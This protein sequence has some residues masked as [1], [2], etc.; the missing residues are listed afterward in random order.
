MTTATATKQGQTKQG[1]TKQGR[2]GPEYIGDGIFTANMLKSWANIEKK[3]LSL[4]ISQEAIDFVK[5]TVIYPKGHEEHM[6]DAVAGRK[7][8][9][10]TSPMTARGRAY[11]LME[12]FIQNL[13]TGQK[14]NEYKAKWDESHQK[15]KPQSTRP[16]L[17]IEQKA[18][19]LA[20]KTLYKQFRKEKGLAS[21][22]KI[23]DELKDDLD[24]YIK[25]NIKGATE[26]E[27]QTLLKQNGK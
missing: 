9:P 22:G 16:R 19:Q 20:V 8:F 10:K 21:R 4:D 12:T 3:L 17:S 1:Q 6:S 27:K 18:E 2:S 11:E 7:F 26:S 15:T 13:F 5:H 23:N 25:K 14:I 24:N